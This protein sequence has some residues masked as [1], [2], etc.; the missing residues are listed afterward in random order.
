MTIN[1][2]IYQQLLD[3]GKRLLTESD[4]N[5]LLSVAMDF[6]I[7]LSHA[8]RG[9][10]IL[11][12]ENGEIMFQTARNL[13]RED[14][15]HP[16]FEI[17][18]TIIEQVKFNGEPICHQNVLNDQAFKESASVERL[19]ILSIICSPLK[20]ESKIFGV[21]YLDNRKLSGVFK[22]ETCDFIL[23]FTN[24]ISLAAYH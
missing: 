19:K 1:P 16:E 10:V 3:L 5:R 4:V 11:F 18:R 20:Y 9:M 22:Q 7:E 23:E 8:E 24:F 2:I 6:A 12:D 15:D 14:L 21:A 13:Q 17:S